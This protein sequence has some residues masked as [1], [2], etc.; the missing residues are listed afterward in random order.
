MPLRLCGVDPRGVV[1]ARVQQHD[2][3]ALRAPQILLHALEIEALRF[4]VVVAVGLD[5][6]ATLREDLVVVAP[7]GLADVDGLGGVE[8]GQ[9]LGTDAQRAGACIVRTSA[10]FLSAIRVCCRLERAHNSMRVCAIR[11]Q[12]SSVAY[13]HDSLVD[14]HSHWLRSNDADADLKIS[15]LIHAS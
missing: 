10:S 11:G 14:E 15:A 1:R 13:S 2:R 8:V 12:R 9:E 7:G 5:G 4:G 3:A 6:E